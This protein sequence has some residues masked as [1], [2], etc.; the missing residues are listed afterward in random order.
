MS[1]AVDD[2]YDLLGVD[3]DAPVDEIR[4]AYRDKKAAVADLG[5]DAAKADAAALNKAWN[6]LSDPYQ[7]GRYD[8]QRADAGDSDGDDDND[9]AAPAVRKPVRSERATKSRA[10][11]DARAAAKPTI[12][13]PAGLEF[14]STRRRIIAMFIDI[15]MLLVLFIAS[16]FLMISMEK[17]QH[18]TV[19]D[20]VS[21]LN[22]KAIPDAHTATSKANK[23]ASAAD[24]AY[25][26][27]LKAKGANALETQAAKATAAKAD[28]V[29]SDAKKAEKKLNDEL[30]AKQKTLAPIQNL[31][32]G[33][34]FLTCLLVLLVPSL[35]GGQTIGKRVQHIRVVRVDGSRARAMDLFRRYAVLV[36]AAYILSSFLRSPVGALIVVFVATMWTRNPNRQ[37][38]HDRF[39]KTLVVADAEE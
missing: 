5:T 9:D 33:L 18:R 29:A 12:K 6:V 39:A 11:A 37:A 3:G 30:T 14:P 17:S 24:K 2:Y 27:L 38:L 34:F 20:R 19:Y 32:S 15:G 8:Q 28:Q 26:D 21:H 13:L 10:R 4:A 22:T 36:F 31:I 7:R 35:F 23:T 1:Q 16:Q 25:A